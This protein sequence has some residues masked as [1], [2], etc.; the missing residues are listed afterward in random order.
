MDQ[1]TKANFHLSFILLDIGKVVKQQ[2]W[3]V[4]FSK[5]QSKVLPI[6]KQTQIRRDLILGK[7]F[8]V[9]I[10]HFFIGENIFCKS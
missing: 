8:I 4:T 7:W 10:E 5:L 6:F 2:K 9:E 3:V 1:L